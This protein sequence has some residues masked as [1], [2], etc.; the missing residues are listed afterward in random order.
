MYGD[1][2]SEVICLY[3]YAYMLFVQRRKLE[4]RKAAAI[5][6]T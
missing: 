4:M 1:K 3:L 5:L 6:H 2:R